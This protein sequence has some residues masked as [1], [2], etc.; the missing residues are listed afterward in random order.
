MNMKTISWGKSKLVLLGSVLFLSSFFFGGQAKAVAP[1]QWSGAGDGINFSHADNWVGGVA[2]TASDTALVT[3]TGAIVID[4][5]TEVAKLAITSS[6]TGSVTLA[7]GVSVTTTNELLL[8][9]GSFIFGNTNTINVGGDFGVSSTVNMASGTLNL[10][11]NFIATTTFSASA[12]TVNFNGAGKSIS[13]PGSVNLTF[14][15]LNIN[16]NTTL[17]YSVTTTGNITVASTKTFALGAFNL[18]TN[19]SINN[20]G[21]ISHAQEE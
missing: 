5:D 1:I 16:G 11:G 12:G 7:S 21:T 3:T 9:G 14:P 2:P 13:S 4:T 8:Q 6:F 20:S 10:S 15:A 19:S 18:I 17:L